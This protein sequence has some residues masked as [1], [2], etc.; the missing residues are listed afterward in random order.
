MALDGWIMKIFISYRRAE[1]DR[2]YIVGQIHERLAAEFGAQNVFRDTDGIHGGQDWRSVLGGEIHT[3]QVMVVV[4]G[5]HWASL[6]D[7][8]GQKR[9]LDPN[10][11]TR[12]EVEAGLLRSRAGKAAVIPLLV[13]EAEIPKQSELPESLWGLLERNVVRLRNYPDFNRD[14]ET[15]L[16]DIRLAL[17]YSSD[18][19]ATEPYEPRTIRLAGGTFW[20][21][22]PP[23]ENI[24]HYERPRHEVHLPDF[25]VGKYPLTNK[26]YEVF[27]AETHIEVPRQ[28]GWEGQ[29][30]PK[31]REEVPVAG[32]TWYEAL[33]YCEWLSR[34]TKR[35]YSLPTE[36][37]WEKACRGGTACQYPW[38]DEF[39]PS[40]CN[41]GKAELTP[42]KHYP[43][44]N[45]YGLFDLVGNVRQWTCT[46]W[47]QGDEP[48]AGPYPWQEDGRNDLKAG[49]ETQRVLRG[50]AAKDTP[51]QHRC[52]ARRGD[53]PGS[54]GFTGARYG[55][56]VVMKI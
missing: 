50:S 53:Y 51:F 46:L 42:V 26:E 29:K 35:A 54:R 32:V 27:V 4:I 3:C 16:H 44:Q 17:G 41:Q 19:L 1:D 11:V 24:P 55:F 2:T 45:D 39:D 14:F 5:P 21:G 48:Q 37:Q 23:G 34:R 47:E 30:V 38:G 36:A 18:D 7:A 6:A 12:W 9:L 8:A 40:R 49:S 10:D 15:L 20:M 52:S 22:S 31:G 43:A 28:L 33:A 25:R 56:R 13:L